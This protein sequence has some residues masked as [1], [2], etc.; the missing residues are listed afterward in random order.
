M[1]N[2][3]DLPA[4]AQPDEFEASQARATRLLAHLSAAAGLPVA[5]IG[6]LVG[7]NVTLSLVGATLFGLVALAALRMEGRTSRMIVAQALT[8]Q[9]ITL[10]AAL[11]GH[12]LQIDMHMVYFAALAAMVMMSG[13][14]A[15]FV[16][17]GTIAVH[18][19]VLSFAMP[20]LVYP[21]TDMLFNVERTAIHAVIVIMETAALSFAIS[22]RLRLNRQAK[23]Q[24]R[25]LARAISE[26]EDALNRAEAEKTRA[27]TALAEAQAARNAADAAR[28]DAETALAEARRQSEIAR[29]A[30]EK[31]RALRD[32]H[33]QELVLLTDIFRDRLQ[34]LAAG[35]LGVRIGDDLPQ[36]YDDLRSYFNNA[37]TRLEDAIT[38]VRG[39]SD[40]IR[41][42]A[43]D[44]TEAGGKLADRSERQATT[45]AQ[46]TEALTQLDRATQDVA[47][48][49][50]D[51]QRLMNDASSE[52]ESGAT[53]MARAVEAMDALEVRSNEVS[54]IIGVIEDIAFQTNLLALNAGVEAARAG[55]A[56]RGFAVVATEVRALAQRSS[57]AAKEI[58]T[59]IKTSTTQVGE[60][61]ALVR[62]T[63]QA[64]DGIQGGV[65]S[66]TQRFDKIVTSTRAQ[67]KGLSNVTSAITDLESLTQKNL[68]IFQE[69]QAANT[70]LDRHAGELDALVRRFQ[71][72]ASRT[73]LSASTRSQWEL[74][75]PT[76][77][78]IAS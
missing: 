29:E 15:L 46:I 50:G 55:D 10:N 57:E 1:T 20:A 30:E 24:R 35:E 26:T 11:M 47:T 66:I 40:A 38:D 33:A 7:S 73:G 44:L 16:A 42:L 41:N 21:S 62:E 60:C 51:A 77:P 65:N 45:L 61:V 14:R 6:W 19:L 70:V 78:R 5:V 23:A 37:A 4:V 8:G 58:D 9:C 22:T 31:D 12:P 48:D 17:A 2:A 34:Q 74:D 18:H 53:V 3:P 63:G 54:K 72:G 43:S 56:G 28:K 49:T 76:A 64:L 36:D 13:L 67:S 59:L 39:Q 52:A 32:S 69:T 75:M 71:V 25:E 68:G 27:E